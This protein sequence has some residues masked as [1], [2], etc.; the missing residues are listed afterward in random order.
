MLVV[1]HNREIAA[2]RRSGRRALERPHRR[3]RSADGGTG[4]DRRTALVGAGGPYAFVVAV[5]WRDLRRRWLLVVAVAPSSP[6]APASIAGL[7]GTSQWRR[8]SYSASYRRWRSTTCACSCRRARRG[9]GGRQLLGQRP[10]HRPC[11]RDR[12]DGGAAP[13]RHPDRRVA[14][15]GTTI[16]VPGRIVGAGSEQA[17][18]T[19]DRVHVFS[20][21]GPVVLESKFADFYDLPSQGTLR[22]S[23]S[24]PLPYGGVGV[25]PEYF[26][27]ADR[28]AQLFGE[29]DLAIVLRAAGLGAGGGRPARDGERARRP[30]RARYRQGVSA[31]RSST[32]GRGDA[33]GPVTTAGDEQ[34][35]RTLYWPRATRAEYSDRARLLLGAVFASFNLVSRMVSRSGARSASAWRWGRA[36]GPSR[37]GRCS[38]GFRSRCSAPWPAWVWVGGSAAPCARCT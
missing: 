7:G 18:P 17:E 28:A 21:D 37:S 35:L 13:C 36:R 14:Q 33:V 5:V 8:L 25:S 23:G 4:R 11:R 15:P 34:G 2:R 1:T 31:R 10:R 20:G 29:D 27:V 24:R 38:S 22:L 9:G 30:V 12:L 26:R 32:G 3:R 19:I 16:L 6:S